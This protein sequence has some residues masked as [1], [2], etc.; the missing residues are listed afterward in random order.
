M[1]LSIFCIF[2]TYLDST[3]VRL[4]LSWCHKTCSPQKYGKLDYAM[5]WSFESELYT[6]DIES[7]LTKTYIMQRPSFAFSNAMLLWAKLL[8]LSRA[9]K[10]VIRGDKSLLPSLS[11]FFLFVLHQGQYLRNCAL[12]RAS[13][14][15]AQQVR[16][17]VKLG[18]LGR[19]RCA[20][21]QLLRYHIYVP[22]CYFIF[23]SIS[24]SEQVGT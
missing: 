11:A 21:T 22:S 2:F 6:F 16:V 4:Q 23:R 17:N 15:L 20:V 18:R 10:A 3:A 13:R 8:S 9:L 24:V 19:G 12:S 14:A 5:K 7:I 1:W